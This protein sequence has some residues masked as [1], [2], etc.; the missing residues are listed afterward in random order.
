MEDHE[1][2]NSEDM[3]REDMEEIN[4]SIVIPTWNRSELV[5][6][7]LESLY[8]D[9]K[10]YCYGK[11]EV[12]IIDSSKDEEKRTIENACGKYDAR[13]IDGVDSVRKKRN[14]GIDIAKYE[15]ILFIDSDVTVKSGLLNTHAKTFLDNRDNEKLAGSFGLT[16][17]VG[18]KKFWWKVL[19]LTTF[20]DSFSFAKRYPY[21]SWTI[22]NNVAFRKEVLLEIG[23]FEE[24]F[25]YKLG[26]D[27]LD[28]TYRV[29]KAGYLIKT[30]PDAVTYHSRE[31]WNNWKAVND[32]SKRWGSMEYHILKRHPELI[33][34]RLPMT[35]DVVLF[36]LLIFGSMSLIRRT[37]LPMAFWGIW[38]MILYGM[39]FNHYTKENKKPVNLVYWTIAMFLQG[40]YRFHRLL[41]SL[42]MHDMSLMFK[43]Q[44]FGIFHVRDDYKASAKKAWIYYESFIIITLIMIIYLF[45]SGRR[46]G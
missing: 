37:A 34:R 16:E 46:F 41:M 24:N 6:R 44:Y 20:V 14:K 27:D 21:V 36:M 23:K 7:L 18:E 10:H 11:T 40:K 12:L 13:Y 3:E 17:F 26:G 29:T 33:R 38:C 39:L 35:G 4:I 32:R 30:S 1:F 25:P 19:E 15:Y 43:G 5:E 28:M 45:V 9:R 8:E 31:T 22:G 2:W 42:R